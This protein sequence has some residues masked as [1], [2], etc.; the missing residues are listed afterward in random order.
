MPIAVFPA[1]WRR[2]GETLTCRLHGAARERGEKSADRRA[3]LRSERGKGE[4]RGLSAAERAAPLGR[5]RV[6]GGGRVL[7][8]QRPKA[9]VECGIKP[10]HGLGLG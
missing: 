1:Q 4:A 10:G 3:L 5:V 9:G 7:G 2:R 6:A 8:R